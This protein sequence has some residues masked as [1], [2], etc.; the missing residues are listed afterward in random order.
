[1]S[2]KEKRFYASYPPPQIFNRHLYAFTLLSLLLL[3][4]CGGDGNN[5]GGGKPNTTPSLTISPT[6]LQTIESGGSIP[7]TVTPT[8]TT[9]VWPEKTGDTANYTLS[10]NSAVWYPPTEPRETPYEFTVTSADK[11]VT[12]TV[13]ATVTLPPITVTSNAE[14]TVYADETEGLTVSFTSPGDWTTTIEEVPVFASASVSTAQVLA[15]DASVA[16]TWVSI[17]PA[18]GLKGAAS[19]AVKLEENYSGAARSANIVISTDS[20]QETVSVTQQAVTADGKT[21]EKKYDV[22]VTGYED[23]TTK[24]VG[25]WKNG[26][27]KIPEQTD[28]EY[29]SYSDMISIAVS[30]NDVYATG[31]VV[32][33]MDN[34]W[35]ARYW[36]NGEEFFLAKD[37]YNTIAYG[38]TLS[39]PVM[40]GVDVY[41]AGMALD[42]YFTGPYARYWKNGV[43]YQLPASAL[44]KD[45]RGLAIAV[46]GADVYVAGYV[47][48]SE[49]HGYYVAAYWKNG[50]RTELTTESH[51]DGSMT[52]GIAVSGSD[53]YVTGYETDAD[54]RRLATLW[55]NGVPTRLSDGT[56]NVYACGIF[57]DGN[58][59]YVSGWEPPAL[60]S[61]ASSVFYWKNS[62]R[63]V[64][65]T[66]TESTPSHNG[67]NSITVVNGDVYVAGL[68]YDGSTTKVV[69]WK[70]GVK[71]ELG[72]VYRTS[73][74]NSESSIAVVPH[75]PTRTW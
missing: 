38:I 23:M 3:T 19:F 64:L 9:V 39:Q 70:N 25:Y 50:V 11:S 49:G 66:N 31:A 8:N 2:R 52:T 69:Y 30:G 75:S 32:N 48:R 51:V 62:E 10:G 42:D 68:S 21:P 40:G 17:N 43:V 57:I 7:I 71:T 37:L 27:L 58:D 65:E 61:G 12:K 28:P 22:Y 44:R 5:G 55:K 72:T 46:S 41:I 59:V 13:K 73:S 16:P 34:G 54:G 36:K 47:V 67:G 26:E 53:V 20:D 18:S 14:Q 29:M 24:K 45:A 35:S 1:L 15:A 33:P 74:G 56:K 60:N 63:V 4:A 6:A